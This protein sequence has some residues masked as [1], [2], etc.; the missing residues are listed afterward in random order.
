MYVC[1]ENGGVER[2]RHFIYQEGNKGKLWWGTITSS[3][4]GTQGDIAPYQSVLWKLEK[5]RV[6][7]ETT[8]LSE[9]VYIKLLSVIKLNSRF[10]CFPSAYSQF[11]SYL[12]PCQHTWLSIQI[13]MVNGEWSR[14]IWALC[15]LS[16]PQSA[17]HCCTNHPFTHADGGG[18][19]RRCQ[20]TH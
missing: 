18:C 14:L 13:I 11:H 9:Q 12:P 16:S 4:E 7:W 1:L 6:G 8:L 2:G 20:P 17:L 15:Y 3:E 5:M 10:W 19:R